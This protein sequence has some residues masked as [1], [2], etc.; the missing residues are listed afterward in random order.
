MILRAVA[1]IAGIAWLVVPSTAA[2]QAF[3]QD[4]RI[5]NG[6]GVKAGEFELH[7]GVAGEVGYDSNYFQHAGNAQE[8]VLGAYRLRVTP[9]L[10]LE[11]TGARDAEGTGT[12]APPSVK[13]RANLSASYNH[14][15]ATESQAAGDI[16]R[17]SH[18]AGNAGIGLDIL[19]QRTWGGDLSAQYSRM[20][21]ASNDPETAN[22]FSRHTLRGGAGV[23]FRPGGGL[24]DWRLGYGVR[25]TLFEQSG[26]QNLD[27]TQ[28]SVETNGR[29][30]FFPRTA[31]IYRGELTFLDYG[32][33]TADR[34]GGQLLRSQAGI[35]G[36]FTQHFGLL[37]LVG[38][39]ATFFDRNAVP[40]N[41]FDSVIG[42]L[43]VSFYPNPQPKVPAEGAPVGLSSISVGY[44]RNFSLSLFGDY[45]QRDRAYASLSYFLAQQFVLAL[46]GGLSHVTRPDVFA[47]RRPAPILDAGGENRVDAQ[48]LL[49]YRPG[50]SIG[51]NATL[52]YNAMLDED[53]RVQIGNGSVDDLSFARYQA[54]LGVRWFL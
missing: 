39:G 47:P 24:F 37:A 19:P 52:R 7:P 40:T 35:N 48:A 45:F 26:F 27:N 36:L 4:P 1:A 44:N 51:I 14:L 15:I 53:R 46:S 13:F 11:T 21:E 5:A 54:F 28:H 50:D 32:N 34:H 8:P 41:D 25:G 33:G 30:T 43:E 16:S 20:V 10:A 38:W 3:L 22:A 49:E 18:V 12:A 6:I 23:A 9:S 2:A 31:L 29:W 17:Q 42:Q